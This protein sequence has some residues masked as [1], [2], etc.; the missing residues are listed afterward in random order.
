MLM[1]AHNFFTARYDV[2]TDTRDG[3]C[4]RKAAPLQRN[5]ATLTRPGSRQ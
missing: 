1:L 2:I 5:G 4:V 3:A